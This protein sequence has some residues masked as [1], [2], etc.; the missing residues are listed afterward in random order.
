MPRIVSVLLAVLSVAASQT[1]TESLST[2]AS[3]QVTFPD[4]IQRASCVLWQDSRVVSEQRGSQQSF[5]CP[6]TDEVVRCDF[7]GAE[8]VD[9]PLESVCSSRA[10]PV[11]RAEMA[12]IGTNGR[13]ELAMEWLQ[14]EETGTVEIVATRDALADGALSFYLARLDGRFVRFVRAGASPVTMPAATLLGG[15]RPVLPDSHPGGEIIARIQPGRV[16][17]ELYRVEG[18]WNGEMKPDIADV[19]WLRG[20]PAG[21]YSIVPVYP[22]GVTGRP[23]AVIVE[24]EKSTAFAL[25]TEA[26]G[27]IQVAADFM[28][29]LESDELRIAAITTATSAT[30]TASAKKN[31]ARLRHDGECN[32]TISGLQPGRYEVSLENQ[33]GPLVT[34]TIEVAAQTVSSLHLT[35]SLVQVSGLVLLNRKPLRELRVEFRPSDADV[36]GPPIGADIDA[37]GRYRA[38]LPEPGLYRATLRARGV[39]LMGQERELI[40]KSGTNTFDWSLTGGTVAI[41]I[42]G[43]DNRAPVWVTL[44]RVSP[45]GFGVIEE[46]WQLTQGDRL[47]VVVQGLALAEYAVYARQDGISPA[48]VSQREL[49]RLTMAQPEADVALQLMENFGVLSVRDPGGIPLGWASVAITELETLPQL[50]PGVFSLEG[51]VPGTPLTITAPGFTPVRVLAP[52]GNLDVTLQPARQ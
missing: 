28:A 26:V 46:T 34:R 48:R 51:V 22:G 8:P 1:R 18:A 36:V 20:V 13:A 7:D 12:A 4:W 11:K 44:R 14:F 17:P 21:A 49:V 50:N 27:A 30:T 3:V 23:I 10:L 35:A 31:V 33:A 45:T 47:P 16:Q 40:V 29:C 25:R 43:R 9:I 42:R 52:A 19:V 6:A 38:T 37:S 2:R 32:R 24:D 41:Q 5:R 39:A 15:R